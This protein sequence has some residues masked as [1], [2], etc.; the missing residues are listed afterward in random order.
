MSNYG[1]EIEITQHSKNIIRKPIRNEVSSFSKKLLFNSRTLDDQTLAYDI[2]RPDVEYAE[3]TNAQ[4][5]YGLLALRNKTAKS[6]VRPTARCSL[7]GNT[8]KAAVSLLSKRPLSQTKKR[9]L[10]NSVDIIKNNIEVEKNSLLF[11]EDPFAYFSKCKDRCGHRF[12]FMNYKYSRDSPDFSPYELE[13]VPY[14]EIKPEHFTMSVNGVTR[15]KS[16]GDTEHV[17]LDVWAKESSTYL[18]IRKLSTFSK[19]FYWK[20]FKLWRNFVMHQR[21]EQTSNKIMTSSLFSRQFFFKTQIMF[22]KNTFSDVLDKYLLPFIPQR[23]FRL[24]EYIVT[25]TNNHTHLKEEYYEYIKKISTVI[26]DNN[27]KIR[28]PDRMSVKDSDFPETKRRNVNIEQLMI[29]EK[30]MSME[31]EKRLA[32]VGS[33]VKQLS[34]F[35]RLIDYVMLEYLVTSTIGSWKIAEKNVAQD[36]S[37]IFLIDV[38]FSDDG[39]ILLEPSMDKLMETIKYTLDESLLTVNELPRILNLRS[40]EPLIKEKYSNAENVASDGPSFCKF[41]ETYHVFKAIKENIVTQIQRVYIETIKL[42]QVFQTYYPIY[43]KSL[44]WSPEQYAYER[45]GESVNFIFD[46]LDGIIQYDPSKL[47]ILDE[48]AIKEDVAYFRK[49]ETRL[50]SLHT[51]I[52]HGCLFVDSKNLKTTLSPIPSTSLERLEVFLGNIVVQRVDL[53]ASIFRHCGKKLKK[54]PLNLEQFIEFCKFVDQVANMSTYIVNEILFIDSLLS[55]FDVVGFSYPLNM[56]IKK[57]PLLEEFKK[58]QSDQTS[59]FAI[60]RMYQEK[61]IIR[62]KE[63]LDKLQG[64]FNDYISYIETCPDSVQNVDKLLHLEKLNDIVKIIESLGPEVEVLKRFQEV[65]KV[66]FNDMISYEKTLTCVT[67]SRDVIKAVCDWKKQKLLIYM[68][69]FVQIDVE[70]LCCDI[71]ELVDR[72]NSISVTIEVMNK[73]LLEV[74]QGFNEILPYIPQIKMLYLG[75]MQKVHWDKLFLVCGLANKYNTQVRII[76]LIDSGVL[77]NTTEIER[78]TQESRGE[79]ELEHEF[80]GIL[81]RWKEIQLPLLDKQVKTDDSLLLGNIEPIYQKIIDSQLSLKRML[82]LPF[83]KNI[84]DRIID[85]SQTLETYGTILEQWSVFQANWLVLQAFFSLD[86]AKDVLSKESETFSMIKRRWM[87]LI[88][89]AMEDTTMVHVAS[90]PSIVDHLKESNHCCESILSL[91]DKY[92]EYKRKKLP[93]LYLL[94]NEEILS[95]YST[96]DFTEFSRQLVKIFMYVSSFDLH[97]QKSGD[98]I[99]HQKVT[100]TQNFTALRIIG[101][102]GQNSESLSLTKYVACTTTIEDWVSTLIQSMKDSVR[103]SYIDSLKNYRSGSLTNWIMTIGT[104]IAALVVHSSFANEVEECFQNFDNNPMS[105]LNYEK[106]LNSRITEITNLLSTPLA[107]AELNKVSII[108]ATYLSHLE[109]C[110]MFREKLS[111]YSYSVYW[112]N[113]FKIRYDEAK[114]H[115][116]FEHGDVSQHHGYEFWGSFKNVILNDDSHRSLNEIS[117]CLTV[118]SIPFVFGEPGSGKFTTL[119]FLASMAGKFLY[120]IPGFSTDSSANLINVFKGALIN[121]CWVV[122]SG[123][124]QH[125]LFNLSKIYDFLRKFSVMNYSGSN[126]KIDNEII[127]V[128]KGTKFIMTESMHTSHKSESIPSYLKS[129]LKPISL[130][131]PDLFMTAEIRLISFGYKSAKNLSQKIVSTIESISSMFPTVTLRS[132]H[133]DMLYIIDE[134]NKY[135]RLIMHTEQLCFLNYYES[136]KTC[137]EY[138]MARAI[139]MYYSPLLTFKEHESLMSVIYLHLKLFD[140]EEEFSRNIKETQLFVDTIVNGTFHSFF[141]YDNSS[142]VTRYLIDKTIDLYKL[143]QRFPIVI[144]Q[145]PPYS[146]K[147][148]V[149]SMLSEIMNSPNQKLSSNIPEKLQIKSIDIFHAGD[150]W[151]NNFGTFQERCKPRYGIIHSYLYNLC[152]YSGTHMQIIRFDG[153]T[154]DLILNSIGSLCVDN[155]IRTNIF[156]TYKCIDGMRILIETDSPDIASRSFFVNSGLLTM[157][158]II[159]HSP[160]VGQTQFDHSDWLFDEVSSQLDL[161]PSVIQVIR[162]YFVEIVPKFVGHVCNIPNVICSSEMN[163]YSTDGH[164]YLNHH[165]PLSAIK[166][167]LD[168]LR[169]TDVDFSDKQHIRMIMIA[170]FYLVFKSIIKEGHITIFDSWIKSTFSVEIPSDWAS[171]NVPDVFCDCFQQPSLTSLRFSKGKFIPL[172][173]TRLSKE[174]DICRHMQYKN[175][176]LARDVVVYTPHLLP[177][178]FQCTILVNNGKSFIIHGAKLSGKTSML[179]LLFKEHSDFIPVYVPFTQQSTSMSLIDYLRLHTHV[180]AKDYTLDTDDKKYALIFENL[181]PDNITVCEFIRKL[182]KSPK[183]FIT[184]QND[185]KVIEQVSFRSF[186]VI[187]TTDVFDKFSARFLSLFSPVQHATPATTTVKYTLTQIC[188]VV[189]IPNSLS[190]LVCLLYNTLE[191]N[192]MLNFHYCHMLSLVSIHENRSAENEEMLISVLKAILYE[193]E[194]LSLHRNSALDLVKSAYYEYFPLEQHRRVFEMILC[195]N[196]LLHADVNYFGESIGVTVNKHQINDLSNTLQEASLKLQPPLYHEITRNKVVAWSMLRR[197]ISFPTG[198]AILIGKKGSGRFK[199]SKLASSQNRFQFVSLSSESVTA[200]LSL[201]NFDEERWKKISSDLTN[202]IFS[203]NSM[204][205]FVRAE[206]TENMSKVQSLMKDHNMSYILDKDNLNDLYYRFKCAYG[207]HDATLY[208]IYGLIQDILKTKIH[209]IIAAESDFDTSLFPDYY[210][211]NLEMLSGNELSDKSNDVFKDPMFKPL[212]N[213]AP[214]NLPNALLKIHKQIQTR[215]PFVTYKDFDDFTRLF[216]KTSRKMYDELNT[217]YKLTSSAIKFVENLERINVEITSKID[218]TESV[219]N[220]YSTSDND[221]SSLSFMSMRQNSVLKLVKIEDEERIKLAEYNKLSETM[222]SNVNTMNT[223]MAELDALR[224]QVKNLTDQD[225]HAIYQ[226]LDSPSH[227]VSIT[228]QWLLILTGQ[229]YSIETIGKKFFSSS[230][231]NIQVLNLCKPDLIEQKVLTKAR[232]FY[233]DFAVSIDVKDLEAISNP[234]FVIY[235]YVSAV[236]KLADLSNIQVELNALTKSKKIELDTFMSDAEATKIELKNDIENIDQEIKDYQNT[237][238]KKEQ[239]EK[240]YEIYEAKRANLDMLYRGLDVMSEEWMNEERNISDGRMFILGNAILVSSYIAY[241]GMMNESRR[242]EMI[243]MVLDTVRSYKIA[244]NMSAMDLVEDTLKSFVPDTLKLN[245][246]YHPLMSEVDFIHTFC[247]VRTPLVIDPD[248]FIHQLFLDVLPKNRVVE[249]SQNSIYFQSIVIESI[250]K[251]ITVLVMDVHSLSSDLATILPF[252]GHEN[253]NI[254]IF[255]ERVSVHPEF[256]VILFLSKL[257]GPEMIPTDLYQRVTVINASD[258]SLKSMKALITQKLLTFSE[259]DLVSR[260]LSVEKSFIYNQVELAKFKEETLRIIAQIMQRNANNLDYDFLDDTE[261][262]SSLMRAKECYFAASNVG[263]ENIQIISEFESASEIYKQHTKLLLCIWKALTR[264]MCQISNVYTYDYKSY[265]INVESIIHSSGFSQGILSVKRVEQLQSV[266]IKQVCLKYMSS[267]STQDSMMFLF[268]VGFLLYEVENKLQISDF[269]SIVDH[270]YEKYH[271]KIDLGISD[272]KRGEALD[273]LKFTNI[274]NIYQCVTRFIFDVMGNDLLLYEHKFSFESVL[275]DKTLLVICEPFHDP[276]FLIERFISIRSSYDKYLHIIVSETFPT[277]FET[278]DLLD[279]AIENNQNVL[280]HHSKPSIA[281]GSYIG[282]VYQYLQSKKADVKMVVIG[283]MEF[284]PRDLIINS[285]KEHYECFPSIKQQMRS[286]FQIINSSFDLNQK[287]V[288]KVAYGSAILYSLTRF[289]E[290]FSPLGVSGILPLREKDLLDH[291]HFV[292][293]HS[294]DIHFV[295]NYRDSV[296]NSVV[297]SGV[298]NIFDRRKIKAL[299]SS[300]INQDMFEDGYIF[301][302]RK[303]S[304]SDRFVITHEPLHYIDR[305]PNEM[306]PDPLLMNVQVSVPFLHYNLSRWICKPFLKLYTPNMKKMS[307]LLDNYKSLSALLPPYINI[308]FSPKGPMGA[309]LKAESTRFNSLINMM[310]IDIATLNSESVKDFASGNVPS[311]WKEI[312]DYYST[313]STKKFISNLLNRHKLITNWLKTNVTPQYVSVDNI[314]DIYGLLNAYRNEFAFQRKSSPNVLHY[315]FKLITSFNNAVGGLTLSDVYMIGGNIDVKSSK[316]IAPNSKTAP[317]MKLPMISCSLSSNTEQ[318]QTHTFCIPMFKDMPSNDNAFNQKN[319]ICT[320]PF[321]TDVSER[322]LILTGTCLVCQIPDIYIDTYIS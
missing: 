15:I 250:S 18:S 253:K 128:N 28:N 130:P 100:N 45:G 301:I 140:S 309:F 110:R 11:S 32:A 202:I 14:S 316:I 262:S 48:K 302:D 112:K 131:N 22:L 285:T 318:K 25:N 212:N 231:A 216:I 159:V 305:I 155:I 87:S 288:I 156:E 55:L 88:R 230:D 260:L 124:D 239:L 184:N 74:K 85:L 144:I 122:F 30:K 51:C 59:S 71:E 82:T 80:S 223:T 104:Y 174:P 274:A 273:Q 300:V 229:P 183:F 20:S 21:F 135:L 307:V 24:Q 190:E 283:G 46:T 194:F 312:I 34:D 53:F 293:S 242:H 49:E 278:R 109:L 167:S 146:G 303:S 224:E 81:Q 123:V 111:G 271:G 70:R 119:M 210:V 321:Q 292:E 62:V 10:L 120:T 64:D 149:F 306:I 266:L 175:I 267:M 5:S 208:E 6:K 169:Y 113:T 206:D 264:Y 295:K 66:S 277:P 58:F 84:R 211:V 137:E 43:K 164:I 102:I 178:L 322:Q 99:T 241:F 198:N 181:S 213:I 121:G 86:G 279:Q 193:M 105:F 245:P 54:E 158:N 141:D 287:N 195:D 8:Q 204:V 270:M 115:L 63:R 127:S 150:T 182:I 203:R 139:F 44:S 313:N 255:G 93:R 304:Y 27:E 154:D 145:G 116:F 73:L 286:L 138:V 133:A 232:E 50:V 284:I 40:L 275:T 252:I 215:Y 179:K 38:S 125:S 291:I 129:I 219:L 79:A 134:G 29:L 282:S 67:S 197:A 69:P 185:P 236:Y 72:V 68:T 238:E 57:N 103:Q 240:D 108:I 281:S 234:L 151:N 94:S 280:I 7:I 101:I 269:D 118:N 162:G 37:S 165:L 214:D 308:D 77:K 2:V 166:F 310:N 106:I 90:F 189:G 98:I 65:L 75:K 157:S 160:Q 233:E 209:F 142:Q 33:E 201:S 200:K 261:I 47:I 168:Y 192:R 246:N 225:I 249:V 235:N 290:L 244:V 170:S 31:R 227:T 177:I 265:L 114:C 153:P 126:V 218:E 97:I 23:K 92:L 247:A 76:D 36:M 132:K 180:I 311:R 205:I 296:L 19:Y 117:R 315:E 35:I 42:C 95:L 89:Y 259:P 191:T 314:T 226:L 272:F 56:N 96:P 61:F 294:G 161:D 243:D 41:I 3:N 199:L 60:K 107:P 289:S 148:T 136:M 26:L 187:V 152:R 317:F 176:V 221:K 39:E 299:A 237:M 188:R 4:S 173:C 147:S 263:N 276:T 52:V 254:D 320:L 17:S 78:I 298:I 207:M 1:L 220:E 186:I 163:F 9:R 319:L 12:I 91:L 83:T 256:K 228:V 13:K 257:G 172:D 143:L 258:G 16:D 196:N 268:T 248:D 297:G 171:F 217:K 251:P 222:N